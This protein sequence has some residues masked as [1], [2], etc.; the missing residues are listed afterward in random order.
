MWSFL[1][2]SI[3]SYAA[4]FGHGGGREHVQDVDCTGV[5]SNLLQCIE[6]GSGMNALSRAC[7]RP[8]GVICEGMKRFCRGL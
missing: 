6:R 8:A 3:V 1:N 7:I 5:A 2:F 4:D